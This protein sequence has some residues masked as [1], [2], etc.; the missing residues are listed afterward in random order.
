MNKTLLHIIWA[1]LMMIPLGFAK[2]CADQAKLNA[3]M[4]SDPLFRL[5]VEQDHRN[6]PPYRY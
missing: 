5:I 3:R 6:G 4:R 1:A 2:S